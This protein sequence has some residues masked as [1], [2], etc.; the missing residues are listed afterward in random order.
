MAD[1]QSP[2]LSEMLISVKT[3]SLIGVA[4]RVE[5]ESRE[6]AIGS[7]VSSRVEPMTYKI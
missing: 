2:T 1:N 6:R 3:N 7:S 5:R 4:Q